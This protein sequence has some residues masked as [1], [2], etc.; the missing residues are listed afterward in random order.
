MQLRP[1][2]ELLS[3]ELAASLKDFDKVI[4]QAPTGAGKTVLF[5]TICQRYTTRQNKSVLIIVHRKEL[6]QQTRNTLFRN[7]DISAEL[8]VAGKKYIHPS[9]VYIGMIESLKNRIKK[10]KNVGLVIIDECHIGAFHKAHKYFPDTKIIGFTATPIS[11]SKKDPLKNHYQHIVPG[12]QISELIKEGFL[13]QNITRVPKETVDRAELKV[14]GNDFDEHLMAAEYSKARHVNNTVEAYRKWCDGEKT[15]IFNVNVAHSMEVTKAFI[16]AGLPCKHLD[17]EMDASKRKG[18]LNWFKNTSDAI[19][20][21][22]G[23]LTAGFDEPTIRNVIVNKS[24]KSLPLWLQMT[25]RGSRF[26]DEKFIFRHQHEYKYPLTVKNHF[27]IIDMGGNAID[28]G[29]WCDDRDWQDV[30][31]N[32]KKPGEGIAPVKSCPEC[33]GIVP[34][35]RRVCGCETEYGTECDYTWPMKDRAQEEAFEAFTVITKDIDPERI[36]RENAEKKEFYSFYRIGALLAKEARESF[37]DMSDETATFI[38]QNYFEKGKDWAREITR[39]RKIADPGSKKVIFSPWHKLRAAEFIKE[40]LKASFPIWDD[41]AWD[42][43]ALSGYTPESS[44][45]KAQKQLA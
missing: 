28:H 38:L 39:K 45:W 24:T 3:S 34:A 30:F 19:L 35:S 9:P 11:S 17:G 20:C 43:T 40:Q 4:G 32:P 16:E 6:L 15:I 29:D 1:F 5:S 10:L 26:I 21:N 27:G 13:C 14:K 42:P 8:V 18:I 36:I 33:E 12:P 31:E 22:I 23:I 2:Q 44:N 7:Y 41:K 37:V 25:G